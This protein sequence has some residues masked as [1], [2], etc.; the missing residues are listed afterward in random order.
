VCGIA[1]LGFGDGGGMRASADLR[2]V[3]CVGN[4]VGNWRAQD[5]I[6]TGLG[7]ALYLVAWAT[8]LLEKAGIAIFFGGESGGIGDAEC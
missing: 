1:N 2:T 8:I 4:W 3:L 6:S 7:R 5:G